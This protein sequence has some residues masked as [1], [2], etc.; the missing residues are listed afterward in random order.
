MAKILI[1]DDHAPFRAVLCETIAALNHQPLEASCGLEALAIL[2]DVIPDMMFLDLR[3]PGSDGM[4]VLRKIRQ[5]PAL[6]KIPTVI[7]TGYADATNTIEAIKLGA[8]DHLTK[9]IGRQELKDVIIRAI[10][11]EREAKGSQPRLVNGSE[12]SSGEVL[13]GVSKVFRDVEKLIGF[14]LSAKSAVLISGETGSGKKQ[15]ARVIHRHSDLSDSELNIIPCSSP[16]VFF[17]DWGKAD[18][19][20]LDEL[21]DLN[22]ADQAKLVSLMQSSTK[23]ERP[24]V[25]SGSRHD[26]AT[27]VRSK[28]FREDLYYHLSV[29]PINVP[30]LRSRGADVLVLAEAFL[31]RLMPD[32]PK[33][34]TSGASKALLEYGWPGNIRE[35]Q[36]TI[37]RAHMVARGRVIDTQDLGLVSSE[38]TSEISINDLLQ[39]DFYSAVARLE[40]MLLEKT[41]TEAE[42][43]RTEAARRLGINRQLLYSKLKE[44]GIEK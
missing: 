3:M 17:D 42:D 11:D 38:T 12:Q 1:V 40:K 26:L 43:N 44:H 31:S 21:L 5:D 7:L 27:A 8:F 14:A 30:P 33:I 37:Q 22:T 6:N 35:L 41:L 4:E 28:H 23:S 13:D 36:N 34:L 16:G 24:R 39:L 25:I 2:K 18:A 10:G 15:I 32:N 20:Y 19:V 29:F 9:P